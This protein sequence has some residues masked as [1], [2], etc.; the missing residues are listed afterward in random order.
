MKTYTE[1]INVVLN[2]NYNEISSFNTLS[3][4]IAEFDRIRKIWFE[5]NEEVSVYESQEHTITDGENTLELYFVNKTV[6]D[7]DF[8][9]L[10][11]ASVAFLEL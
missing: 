1:V 7:E 11:P 9:M 10:H 8:E 4:A 3:N 2:K 5:E 6:S